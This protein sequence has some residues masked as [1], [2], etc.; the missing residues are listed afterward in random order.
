MKLVDEELKPLF[1]NYKSG[2]ISKSEFCFKLGEFA[3]KHFDNSEIFIY[4]NAIMNYINCGES[5]ESLE[6][7]ENGS[8]DV[9]L[10]LELL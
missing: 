3:G 4:V 9:A 6:K 8:F 5:I 10:I 7:L 2:E 1:R